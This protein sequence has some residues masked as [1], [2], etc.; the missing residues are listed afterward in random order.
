MDDF[1]KRI[2]EMENTKWAN[3]NEQYSHRNIIRVF[4]IAD[5]PNENCKQLGPNEM[6]EETLVAA[7]IVG[8]PCMAD[9]DVGLSSSASTVE[10]TRR[11]PSKPGG[12][13]NAQA[14]QSNR[15]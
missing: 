13:L 5:H 2:T 12:S 7:H 9:P 15:I 14:L 1:R 10:R 6:R 3:R 8:A 4:G 11:R